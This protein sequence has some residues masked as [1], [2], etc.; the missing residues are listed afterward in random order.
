MK[1]KQIPD[2]FIVR[3]MGQTRPARAGETGNYAV[4]HLSKEGIGTLDAINVLS[5]TWSVSQKHISAGGLKDTEK[6]QIIRAIEETNG[7]YSLAAK[8]LGIS[9]S[10]LYQKIKQYQI[11]QE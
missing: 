6:Q 4:Y 11:N 10:T 2:D 7:N 9:R 5:T 3:E 1:I 8:N